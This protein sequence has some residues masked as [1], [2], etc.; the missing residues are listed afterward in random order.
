ME[1]TESLFIEA[2]RPKA[3]EHVEVVVP[4][5]PATMRGAGKRFREDFLEPHPLS[6]DFSD[7][8]LDL[9]AGAFVT[10]AGWLPITTYDLTRWIATAGVFDPVGV[11]DY[12]EE[13]LGLESLDNPVSDQ[14][15]RARQRNAETPAA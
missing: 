8:D 9:I 5:T 13:H 1:K 6:E 15:R 4:V 7:Q 11:A 10:L 2:L 3:P 12:A 14:A